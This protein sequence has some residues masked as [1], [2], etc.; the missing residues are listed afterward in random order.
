MYEVEFPTRS[1]EILTPIV[2]AH[3]VARLVATG[4]QV[5]EEL[6]GRRVVCVNSTA[7]GGGVAEMLAVL[8]AYTGGV[9]VDARWLVIEGNPEFF[10]IT[11]R[12]HNQLHGEPGDGGPLG[13]AERAVLIQTAEQNEADARRLFEP[14]D[15]VLL[16]DPQPAGMAAWLSARRVPLVWRCHVGVD[17]RNQY[18]ENG[19]GFLRPLLEPYID[20]YVFTRPEYAPEWVP[21]GRL[22][23][24]HPSLDPFA[25]KN[26]DLDPAEVLST[27]Q[28][29]GIL[30]RDSKRPPDIEGL[31]RSP[32]HV[33]HFADIVGEGPAPT[34]STPMVVQVSR[35][36]TLKDMGGVMKGFA[37][38]PGT[39]DACLVLAGPDVSSVTDDPEGQQ[40]LAQVIEQ[41]RQLPVEARARILIACL[42]MDDAEENALMVNSLQ[43]HAAI[44]VQKSLKEGFGLTVTEAMLKGRPVVASAVGGIVDQIHDGLDGVLVLDPRDTK[45]LGRALADL[46]ADPAR[47]EQIG[48]AARE[49][50][51]SKFLPDTSLSL[52][53]ATLD[54]AMERH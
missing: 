47:S 13:E 36:D 26:R 8:L 31:P 11:K 6:N 15:V 16:H 40:V 35:W 43:R 48:V 32:G 7:A 51:I 27:L 4:N 5:R 19:W 25:P 45:E 12:L 50:V 53:A 44:V 52:W 24:I 3:N 46:L 17:E 39:K 14:G 9:G 28:H 49:A 1:P 2:G 41:W 54:A 34:P 29:I 10:A 23:A 33:S 18:T 30:Q 38:E 42:P 22:H 21:E 37:E 20:Q